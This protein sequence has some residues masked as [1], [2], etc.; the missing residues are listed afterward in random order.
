MFSFF[1]R[2]F[3]L[4]NMFLSEVLVPSHALIVIRCLLSWCVGIRPI[5]WYRRIYGH[6]LKHNIGRCYLNRVPKFVARPFLV[7]LLRHRVIIRAK[8]HKGVFALTSAPGQQ[9]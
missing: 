4:S 6:V 9:Q 5:T 8:L 3:Y 1:S 2:V 7:L